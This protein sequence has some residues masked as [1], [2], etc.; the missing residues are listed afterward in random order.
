MK[1]TRQI[2]TI[3]MLVLMACICECLATQHFTQVNRNDT[4]GIYLGHLSIQSQTIDNGLDEIGAFYVDPS[5]KEYLCGAAIL[6]ETENDFFYI[7]VFSDDVSTEIKDGPKSGDRLLFKVW[8]HSRN[9]EYVV[10]S[11]HISFVEEQYFK[12]PADEIPVWN[13]CSYGMMKIEIHPRLS[14]PSFTPKQKTGAAPLSVQFKNTS[15]GNI[16]KWRWNFGDGFTSSSKHPRHTYF[17]QGQY[18]VSLIVSGPDG[19]DRLIKN[20][21]ITVTEPSPQPT[22][23]GKP[24]SGIA[25]LKVSFVLSDVDQTASVVWNFG[26]DSPS[27][28]ALNP[29]HTYENPGEY[30]VVATITGNETVVIEKKQYIHVYGRKLSGM[31]TGDGQPLPNAII[32]VWDARQRMIA[33]TLSNNEGIY[34]INS[35]P[36]STGLIA[37]VWPSLKHRHAWLPQF[38]NQQNSRS[39]A[40][41]FSTLTTDMS[42][43]FALTKTPDFTIKG[44]VHDQNQGIANMRVFAFSNKLNMGMDTLSDAQGYYTLTGLMFSEDYI[45]S[46]CV[47]QCEVEFFY[48]IPD[49]QQAGVFI[50]QESANRIQQATPVTP[51][52]PAL[53]GID[54]IVCFHE[55][56]GKV[57]I[58]QKPV[59][60]VWVQAWSDYLNTGGGTLTNEHG[61]Y[62]IN[63]LKSVSMEQADV[64][65]YVVEI[66]HQGF[67]YQIYPNVVQQNDAI[68][69]E[70]GRSDIDFQLPSTGRITGMIQDSTGNALANVLVIAS[71]QT[72]AYRAEALSDSN[73]SYTLVL[74]IADDYILM[75]NSV[76]YPV[77]Y[78]NQQKN[79]KNAEPVSLAKG[80]ISHIDFAFETGGVIRGTIFLENM[81]TPAPEGIWINIWSETT[82]TGGS[83][84]TDGHGRYEMR[85]LNNDVSD[86]IIGIIEPGYLPTF[87][88]NTCKWDQAEAVAPS[89]VDRNLIM[90]KGYA[91]HGCVQYKQEPYAGITIEAWSENS[92]GWRKVQSLNQS[93]PNYVLDG[94]P[95]GEYTVSID[96]AKFAS[97]SQTIHIED[98]DVYLTT[99][100]LTKNN[101]RITGSIHGLNKKTKAQIHVW[102]QQT[103]CS[104]TQTIIGNGLETAY[105]ITGLKPATDY[106]VRLHSQD[107]PNWYY[108]QQSRWDDADMVDISKA[109]AKGIDFVLTTAPVITGRV[110]VD[111]ASPPNEMIFIN[112]FSDSTGLFNSTIIMPKADQAVPYTIN[113]M[114]RATDIKVF[115]T[116]TTYKK[117]YYDHVER[118]DMAKNI[119]TTDDNP[120]TEINFDL[121]QGMYIAGKIT[122]NQMAVKDV[123]VSAWS[124]RLQSGGKVRTLKNG[125][126][127]IQGLSHAID[128]LVWAKAANTSDFYYD[129]DT[130]TQLKEQAQLISILSGNADDIDIS[131]V[132]GDSI[133]GTIWDHDRKGLANIWV[134]VYSPGLQE[135]NGIYSG[136]DGNYE[137]NGLPFANDYIVH[138]QPHHGLCY[139]SQKKTDVSS[140]SAGINFQLTQGFQLSGTLTALPENEPISKMTIDIYSEAADVHARVKTTSDGKYDICGLPESED[141]VIQ[142]LPGKQSPYIRFMEKGI[143]ISQDMVKNIALSSG[144]RISGYVYIDYIDVSTNQ[145]YTSGL[146]VSAASTDQNVFANSQ[147]DS[148][149]FYEIANLPDASD[150]VITISPDNY[151]QQR[152]ENQ[153]AGDIVNFVLEKTGRISGTVKDTSGSGFENVRITAFSQALNS[154]KSTRTDVNGNYIIKGLKST[155]TDYVITAHTS[156]LGYPEQTIGPKRLGDIVHFTLT[157][158][159]SNTITGSIKDS[160]D[161]SPPEKILI[162]AFDTSKTGPPSK[163]AVSNPDGSFSLTGLHSDRQYQLLFYA[164]NNALTVNPRQWAG[165]NNTGIPVTQKNLAKMYDAGEHVDFQF[166]GVW[167]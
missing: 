89:L 76:D 5:G 48:A 82:Q 98:Q 11:E 160:S 31:V 128:Y 116:S 103:G 144:F 38:Y 7:N 115:A 6:G 130:G 41:P 104:K 45:V 132:Q 111:N 21:C 110:T 95:S 52:D 9:I 129:S 50:P 72:T 101:H 136:T 122:M 2:V 61:R 108:N 71:S 126:Y 53:T 19:T 29:V 40:T 59:A 85:G 28:Q 56:S 57:M 124:E 138:V 30:T 163:Q 69:V 55:I 137:L 47:D 60:G 135:G 43:D 105:I 93:C 167:E 155:I 17:S 65:G 121:Y 20:N 24:T 83:V 92:L 68:R 25:P 131:L 162:M 150:Y 120:D 33:D 107:H 94:L 117:Q 102:S 8:D 80:N 146:W 58:D 77:M 84:P 99:F 67:P 140:N 34:E 165:E 70:T 44:K 75:A 142:I 152:K 12:I 81:D 106:R 158:G 154:G 46:T 151:A 164:M 18:D 26:D 125:Q 78:Y 23:H 113:G 143:P 49:N 74:P 145:P 66:N 42:I 112:A 119:D 139:V 96:H 134:S 16:D 153:S 4:W 118:Y 86:Y 166:D 22:F 73:G 13:D 62:T 90:K 87:Y 32:V 91:I 79:C 161:T 157:K 100:E 15:T 109:D 147:T 149:G 35:L 114:G 63:G 14:Y 1:R 36:S 123:I 54:L 156:T 88:T 133:S 51:K 159:T 64:R 27:Q 127:M 97:A 10:L 3:T 39:Q 141:Y 37:G 148:N